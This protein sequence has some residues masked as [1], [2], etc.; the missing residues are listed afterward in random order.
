MIPKKCKVF[1]WSVSLVGLII[2]T[3]KFKEEILLMLSI[4]VGT[5]FV[6]VVWKIVY[7]PLQH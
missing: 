5:L 7:A 2:L 4:G 1:S 6:G 3:V